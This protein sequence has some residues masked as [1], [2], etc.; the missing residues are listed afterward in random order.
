MPYL[1][2]MQSALEEIEVF[3]MDSEEMDLS[4]FFDQKILKKLQDPQ[5]SETEKL[6][7]IKKTKKADLEKIVL[8][9]F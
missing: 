2:I 4:G 1:W 3:G 9:L 5:V 6:K 7:I 8:S